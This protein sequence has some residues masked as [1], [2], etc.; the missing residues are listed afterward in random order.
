ML[1]LIARNGL[2]ANATTLAES[3]PTRN[4]GLSGRFTYAFQDKYL[5]EF[6]FGYNGSEKFD[7][8]HR[9]GF[10]P[11]IGLGWLIS[12]EP[13]WGTGINNVISN[14]KVKGTY[15]MVGNDNIGLERFFYLSQVD[16]NGGNNYTTGFDFNGKSRNGVSISNYQNPN[17]GWEIS[18]K[19]NLGIELGLFKGKIDILADI[20][21]E[22]RTNIVQY[23]ADIPSEMGLW[24][25]PQA[26]VGE[27]KGNGIDASLDY[28]HRVNNFW[29]IGRATVT[30]AR[31][32]FLAYEEPDFTETPWRS[33]IGYPLAQQWGYVAERLFIDE[34]DIANSPRQDFGEYGPGDIKYRDIN[35]DNVINELDLVAI[36]APTR[37]ELNY[38]FG[39]S[40]G[41]K[42]LDAS[43]FF[44]GS[45]RSSFWIDADRMAPFI[46][47]DGGVET[48]LAKFIADDYWSQTSQNP[49]AGWPRLSTYLMD[50]NNERNTLFM[51]DG[52]FIRLKSV[53]LGYS[54]PEKWIDRW[55]L[56]LCRIYLSGTN[57]LLFSN[58]DLWDVEMGGNGLGYPLQRVLNVGVHVSF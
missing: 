13:F 46:R 29:F 32:T 10:F 34:A 16:I 44:Q 3:L 49:F 54:L 38:G 53:E 25:T 52:S 41:Y 18:Y 11:S 35:E 7:K 50:N 57:L 21:S 1:V 20:F 30:Y 27:A 17:I 58:F 42:N 6:N 47:K 56:D 39:L 45:G 48:G 51:R 14:F 12:N 24:A 26:N 40:S 19:A 28:N 4:L 15:G 5:G 33:R 31:S 8:G 36:G 23:R 22:H 43:F 9:W 55:N 37:P 2:T